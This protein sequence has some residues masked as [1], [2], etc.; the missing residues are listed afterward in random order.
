MVERLV[1]NEKVMG[2]NPITRSNKGHIMADIQKSIDK[3]M[4]MVSSE[5]YSEPDTQ[6][7]TNLIDKLIPDLFNR[8]DGPKP[9][10]KIVDIGCGSGYVFD[11]LVELGCKKEDMTGVT[12]GQ[13]DIKAV[14]DKGYECFA[15]DMSFTDFKDNTFDFGIV[16]HCLEHSVWP[17]LT[18]MEFNRIMK[19]G[20][21]MYIEMPAPGGDR[22]LEHWQNHYSVMGQTMWGSLM[23]RSGFSYMSNVLPL[24]LSNTDGTKIK[25]PYHWYVIKKVVDRSDYKPATHEYMK[26]LTS[27]MQ[28]ETPK[29]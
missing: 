28:P 12:M 6:L 8:P 10:E 16:R 22:K 5:V 13:D 11:K 19:V 14:K 3:F 24:E 7:H 17:Y 26:W 25:E 4:Q 27:Q 18:L 29:K 1:A 21:R 15:Y 23:I 20:G 2:S 9:G